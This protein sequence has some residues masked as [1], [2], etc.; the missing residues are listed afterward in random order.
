MSNNLAVANN[1]GMVDIALEQGPTKDVPSH[2][3]PKAKK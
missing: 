3:G 1:G 2:S